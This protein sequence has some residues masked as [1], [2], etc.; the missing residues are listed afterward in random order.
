MVQKI[1]N[2][3]LYEQVIE[4]IKDSIVDG[5]YKKGQLLPSE[6][7]LVKTTGVSRITIRE[8]LRVLA[9]VG[10]IEK[11]RGKGSIILLDAKDLILEPQ[12]NQKYREY[13]NAFENST[14][15]RILIEP[16][17]ARQVAII[18]T[19]DDIQMLEDC[20]TECI[21]IRNKINKEDGKLNILEGFHYC[22]LKILD[23]QVMSDFFE[24]LARMEDQRQPSILIPPSKQL[25]ISNEL[26]EQH[27]KVFEAIKSHN[28]EFAYFYMKEHTMYVKEI[29][30]KYFD[31]FF[32]D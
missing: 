11:L 17:I 21:D 20:L 23:N 15:T 9:E 28:S 18:A 7:E 10:I 6:N 32:E 31:D 1:K 24:K 29:Y 13:R 5:K 22:L 27:F 14:N 16:E 26:T 19:D 4:Q 2:I 30:A 8:A 25:T 3:K 12:V